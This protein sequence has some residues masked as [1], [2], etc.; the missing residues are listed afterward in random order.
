MYLVTEPMKGTYETLDTR[1]RRGGLAVTDRKLMGT[2]LVGVAEALA[3]LHSHNIIHTDVTLKNVL[4][5]KDNNIKVAGTTISLSLS[6]C[7]Y[8]LIFAG[9]ALP[10][11][12]REPFY[13]LMPPEH[14]LNS[15]YGK[16]GDIW[17]FGC[18]CWVCHV[19]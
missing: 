7:A 3:H 18:L 13:Q 9:Y 16:T 10:R 6:L 1:L 14:F 8:I 19:L 5:D 17:M 2:I 12:E 11:Q 4:I 15:E